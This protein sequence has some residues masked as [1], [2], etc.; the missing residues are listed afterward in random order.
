MRKTVVA[1]LCV[2]V[3]FGRAR[4]ELFA[5]DLVNKDGVV[6]DNVSAG[7]YTNAGSLLTVRAAMYACLNGSVSTGS[8]L[9]STV[10]AFGINAAGTGDDTA[11]YDTNNG[12]ESLWVSFDRDVI[13][14]SITV[15][16][17]SSGNTE[18]GAYQVAHGMPVSFTSSGTYNIDT[19]LTQGEFL[20][21]T[22]VDE[23]GGNGWSLSSFTIEAIPEPVTAFMLGFGGLAVW[24]VR[25]MARL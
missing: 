24:T 6:W 21:I 10:A 15:A 19:A 2:L 16:S 7:I 14:K 22:A 17:F 18:T 23:G 1:A 4:A 20:K 8:L 3:L 12:Q 5:F 13:I 11:Y 25:R 9:N